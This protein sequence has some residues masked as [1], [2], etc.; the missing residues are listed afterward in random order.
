MEGIWS[1]RVF[2]LDQWREEGWKT[3]SKCRKEREDGSGNDL[4]DQYLMSELQTQE[5][6]PLL[7]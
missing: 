7:S 3:F 2:L 5:T 6:P 1:K 4:M